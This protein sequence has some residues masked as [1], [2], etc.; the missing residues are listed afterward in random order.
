MKFRTVVKLTAQAL[1][2]ALLLP[3]AVSCGVGGSGNVTTSGTTTVTPSV[4]T[5]PDT[6]A[7]S[8]FVVVEKGA[9]RYSIRA[10]RTVAT[11]CAD[12]LALIGNAMSGVWGVTLPV[13]ADVAEPYIELSITG[14]R[15]DY[16]ISLDEAS[17][18]IKVTGGSAAALDR[19]VRVLLAKTCAGKHAGSTDGA[20]GANGANGA[21]LTVDATLDFE[22]VYDRDHTDNSSLLS[23]IP[24]ESVSLVPGNASGSIMTPEWAESLII[25][26]LKTDLASI[27]GS[28]AESH[29]LVDF[30]ASVGVNGLWITPVYEKGKDG[31]GYVNNGPH[32]VDPVYSGTDD[33]AAG[34]QAVRGFVDYAHSRGMYV[35]LDI[36]TWGVNKNAPLIAEHPDWFAGEAWSN[37]AF[38]WA[39]A[40][41][42]E[43]FISVCVDNIMTTGADGYRCDCEPG[44]TGYDIFGAVRSRLAAQG[45]HVLII[46]EDGSDRSATYDFEQDGVLKYSEMDRGT[47][48]Q[49][50]VNFYVDGYLRIVD[51]VKT[52]EGLGQNTVQAD[53]ER[54]GTGKYYT[55]CLSNHDFKRRSVCGDLQKIGYAAIMAP[56]IPLWM[57]GDEFNADTGE[58]TQYFVRVNYGEAQT[59]SKAL[60]LEDVTKLINIRRTNADI[61][62]YWPE[63][64]RESNIC[65]V[66]VEGIDSLQN[67]ARYAG[68]R[69]IIVIANNSSDCAGLGRVTIP[70]SAAG[71]DSH[72]RYTVTDLMTGEV[73]AAG[74]AAEV[75]GFY[76]VVAC[77][78]VGVY[79]V[80]AE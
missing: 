38:N 50:P 56:V 24:T 65:E 35:F 25:V 77:H 79:A 66:N 70:F 34:W 39:N 46:S 37:V 36:I 33:Y 71:I 57:M 42:R 26:E 55:N 15:K 73:I 1:T 11:M 27:G 7:P 68:N 16:S 75:D 54:R 9:S 14:G 61:F 32:T 43:W 67:Y 23:Y 60:F 20:G 76:A 52:G 6:T 28:F 62:E 80:D 64:H 48:Y 49:K 69:A 41:L 18:N 44:V 31:N 63:N 5:P 22:F 30:Y 19:A 10:G 72:A 51:S 13:G 58:G 40:G 78:G 8:A 47:F 2:A 4:T 74:T 3:L 12:S 21:T 53:P 59:D 29:D 17:G 45:K